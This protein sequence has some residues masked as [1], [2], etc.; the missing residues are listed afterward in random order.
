[1]LITKVE[2]LGTS[3]K[4][5]YNNYLTSFSAEFQDFMCPFWVQGV[6]EERLLFW[7]KLDM[8]LFLLWETQG[9]PKK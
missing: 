6:Y 4:Y 1:M 7:I 8:S 3:N 9:L 2:N 5:N